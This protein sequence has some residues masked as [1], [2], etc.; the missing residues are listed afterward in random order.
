LLALSLAHGRIALAHLAPLEPGNS[1][2]GVV[3]FVLE[4][5]HHIFFSSS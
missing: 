3:A 4:T 5:L 2:A 1:P